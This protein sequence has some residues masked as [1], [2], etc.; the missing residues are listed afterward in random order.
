MRPANAARLP[1]RVGVLLLPVVIAALAGCAHLVMLHDPLDASEHNDLG[2]S[3]EAGGQ[4]DLA[5]REYRRA[6]SLDPHDARFRVNLG[7]VE[8]AGAHWASAERCYRRAL[9]DSSTDAD[10]LNNLA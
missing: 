1:H 6:L 4:I 8:A 2:V 10:A 7:N 5:A 3:Y 9:R